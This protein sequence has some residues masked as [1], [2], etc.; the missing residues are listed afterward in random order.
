MRTKYARII[1]GGITAARDVAAGNIMDAIGPSDIA[2]AAVALWD[3]AYWR[4]LHRARN[5]ARIV[6]LRARIDAEGRP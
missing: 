1:R 6:R 2:G 4:T 3:H 5:R